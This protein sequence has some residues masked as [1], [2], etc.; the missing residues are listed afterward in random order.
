[1]PAALLLA[2]TSGLYCR[3]LVPLALRP[4]LGRRYIVRALRTR[5]RDE[6]RITA[7]LF[8]WEV[9]AVFTALLRGGG[10]EVVD[11]KEYLKKLDPNSIRDFG[12]KKITL[13]TGTVIE[14]LKIT[15]DEDERRF[16][17]KHTLIGERIIAAASALRPV[18]AVVR[19]SHERWDGRGYPD[20][21]AG[22]DIPL[23]ARIV[24][25]CD[26]FDAMTTERP[27]RTPVSA[28]EAVAELRRNAGTQFDA[29][30]VAVLA[31]VVRDGSFTAHPP[32]AGTRA[33]G[34]EGP[35][36]AQP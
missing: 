2:R 27:Y 3:V 31:E 32:V 18:G 36:A 33:G 26:A 6:A 23:A 15:N 19:S 9:R 4:I 12:A 13:P 35:P 17:R 1:M 21:L 28:E 16:M 34:P 11:P 5:D 25:A 29:R 7:A 8:A 10:Q 14:G 22:G 30:V 24:C 20:G